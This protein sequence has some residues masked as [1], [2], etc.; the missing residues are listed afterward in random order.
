LN[1]G[2]T[3]TA[4]ILGMLLGTAGFV[5]SILNYLRDRAKVKITLRWNMRIVETGEL[6]GLVRVTNIGRRP[7]FISVVALEV[8]KGFE[9]PYLLLKQSIQGTKL[10][11]SEKPLGLPV[12]YG[13]LS[14]YS[15]VWRKM[16]AYAEDS[17]GKRYYSKFPAKGV[18]TPSW[19]KA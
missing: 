1:D 2:L 17:T 4:S 18:E 6:M 12:S 10:G 5:M 7:V 11:E 8:P 16:R 19:V 13:S 15:K 14:P 3:A 9:Y